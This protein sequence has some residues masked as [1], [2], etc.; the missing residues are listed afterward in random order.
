MSRS[1]FA[2]VCFGTLTI[3]ALTAGIP[4]DHLAKWPLA[5][6]TGCLVAWIT[7]LLVKGKVK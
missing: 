5:I 2:L 6:E 7:M 3:G 1:T 4:A